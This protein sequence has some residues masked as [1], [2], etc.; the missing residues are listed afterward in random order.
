MGGGQT[1][2]E[3]GER[4]AENEGLIAG[5]LLAGAWAEKVVAVGE[6]GDGDEQSRAENG[7]EAENERAC[8]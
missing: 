4:H 3:W 6:R 2:R 8:R 7:G 5:E 1:G